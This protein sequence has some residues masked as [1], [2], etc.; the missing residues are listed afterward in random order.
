MLVAEFVV[1]LRDER[2]VRGRGRCNQVELRFQG[3]SIIQDFFLFDLGS[4][5][6]IL[7]MDWL[8]QL[9]ET[10]KNRK[11]Q[12]M[13]FY[14]EGSRVELKGDLS[15]SMIEST[16]KALVNSITDGGEGYLV[17]FDGMLYDEKSEK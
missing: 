1:T 7:G 11:G 2:K 13:K 10:K 16:L 17:E 3:V 9:G 6:V 8:Y 5:D 14:W 4:V 12:T 15:L